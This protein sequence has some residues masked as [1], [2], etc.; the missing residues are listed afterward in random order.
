MRAWDLYAIYALISSCSIDIWCPTNWC[1]HSII[2]IKMFM[3][4]VPTHR[5]LESRSQMKR[6][7]IQ[8]LKNYCGFNRVESMWDC[9]IVLFYVRWRN[10]YAT[11][12]IWQTTACLNLISLGIQI[13]HLQ[14]YHQED[15]RWLSWGHLRNS[16][17]LEDRRICTTHPS[18]HDI[19]T[20]VARTL[21]GCRVRK[22]T[23]LI[24]KS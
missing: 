19:W 15:I 16:V 21:Y 11:Y 2:K 6:Q 9:N 14:L 24:Q 22:N 23:P 8:L 1:T 4:N 17:A 5:N 18:S 12:S 13:S 20:V 7:W 10:K 3:F